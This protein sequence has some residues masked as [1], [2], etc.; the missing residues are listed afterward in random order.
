MTD[1]DK[2]D[3]EKYRLLQSEFL[4]WQYGRL[5]K[6]GQPE[7]FVILPAS[8]VNISKWLA[9]NPDIREKHFGIVTVKVEVEDVSD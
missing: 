9:E 3:A 6:S 7:N 2:A 5:K 8:H 1:K 4:I